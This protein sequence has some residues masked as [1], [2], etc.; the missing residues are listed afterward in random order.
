[1]RVMKCCTGRRA[2]MECVLS[3]IKCREMIDTLKSSSSPLNELENCS[4]HVSGG[5][6]QEL[7]KRRGTKKNIWRNP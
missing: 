4:A 7:V 1:M 5:S 2:A 6:V 3:P